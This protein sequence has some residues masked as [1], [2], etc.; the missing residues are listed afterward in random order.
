MKTI[1]STDELIEHMVHKGIK[2]NIETKEEASNFLQ[3]NN[4]YFKLAAY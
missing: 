2:F 4:Y 1:L 3:H